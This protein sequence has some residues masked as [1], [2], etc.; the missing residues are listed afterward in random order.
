MGDLLSN[1]PVN[2]SHLPA[3]LHYNITE[4]SREARLGESRISN[5][6]L[7]NVLKNVLE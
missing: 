2:M 3:Y 1:D 5:K 7:E 4:Q 6:G